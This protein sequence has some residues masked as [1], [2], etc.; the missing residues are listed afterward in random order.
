MGQVTWSRVP[1]MYISMQSGS[2]RCDIVVLNVVSPLWVRIDCKACP[3]SDFV[4]GQR[5]L[6]GSILSEI[7]V[8]YFLSGEMSGW[9]VC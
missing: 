6:R 7:E 2:S 1:E 8:L 3:H 4:C 9:G 5:V